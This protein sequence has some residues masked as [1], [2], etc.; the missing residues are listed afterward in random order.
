VGKVYIQI[1]KCLV[2]K[3]LSIVLKIPTAFRKLPTFLRRL[4][5]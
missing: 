1:Q 3:F 4:V 2:K 5:C